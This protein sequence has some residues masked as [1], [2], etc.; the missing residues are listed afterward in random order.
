M[1]EV[2]GGGQ[3]RQ[4]T[5]SVTLFASQLRYEQGQQGHGNTY[6]KR[7]CVLAAN[8]DTFL[9]ERFATWPPVPAEAG[10]RRPAAL[11]AGR[12]SSSSDTC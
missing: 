8:T 10:A 11:W 5:N 7:I 4:L 12:F 6:A 9:G 1:F 3:A 2:P